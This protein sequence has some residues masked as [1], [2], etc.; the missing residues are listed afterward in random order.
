MK[1]KNEHDI[2]QLFQEGLKNYQPDVNPALWD[3]IQSKVQPGNNPQ[4]TPNDGGSTSVIKTLVQSTKFWVV[5][6]VVTVAAI[7]T[8]VVLQ[9]NDDVQKSKE[10]AQEK[11]SISEDVSTSETDN[12]TASTINE[13]NTVT[14]E[15]NSDETILK[16]E[17]N[18]LNADPTDNSDAEN[19]EVHNAEGTDANAE[20]S[21]TPTPVET[22][23][24]TVHQPKETEKTSEKKKEKEVEQSPD[25]QKNR[26]IVTT[27]SAWNTG[28]KYTFS[29]NDE[30]NIVEIDWYLNGSFLGKD[31]SIEVT[32]EQEGNQKLEADVVFEDRSTKVFQKV[33][34]VSPVSFLGTFGP[35][36]QQK[37]LGT[38]PN[39]FSPNGDGKND[40]FEVASSNIKEFN[41]IIFN[42]Q[43]QMV[44]GSEKPDFR[45]DGND[46]YGK[47]LGDN[48]FRY[49]IR[50][51]GKDG[52]QYQT[53]GSITINR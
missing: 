46:R 52:R 14:S 21:N 11:T 41:I 12:E 26:T 39:V 7:T 31:G 23:K 42:A 24:K 27:E 29:L 18:G 17:S 38:L 47:P 22:D 32:F 8:V 48:E 16:E 5:S 36:E 40:Y 4:S 49:S 28:E 51:V 15:Q 2:E 45:W 6:S 37:G 53:E 43:G 50:A 1:L 44:Y 20:D 3:K 34:D 25:I 19:Q 33:V 35:M 13:E 9:Q 30:K 10:L